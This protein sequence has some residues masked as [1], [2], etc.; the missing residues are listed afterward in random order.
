MNPRDAS[1]RAFKPFSAQLSRFTGSEQNAVRNTKEEVEHRQAA[2]F[3][4]SDHFFFPSILPSQTIDSCRQHVAHVITMTSWWRKTSNYLSSKSNFFIVTGGIV[5]GAYLVSQYAI[6]K[7]QQVQEKLVNDKNAKEN[8][9]RRFAQNQED[10]TFT[11]LALLPTLGDQL[12]SK[13]NVEQLTESLRSQAAPAPAAPPALEAPSNH[14]APV[15]TSQPSETPL[16]WC[17]IKRRQLIQQRTDLKPTRIHHP[18]LQDR[19]TQ[20]LPAQSTCKILRS[21]KRKRRC[22][23]VRTCSRHRRCPS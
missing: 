18:R 22:M 16:Q 12:F 23:R 15:E 9:R 17:R 7:F 11:V 5:G 21:R 14:A 13:H 2:L 19:P 1:K 8:L 20:H 3:P 6:S 10:C 4:A